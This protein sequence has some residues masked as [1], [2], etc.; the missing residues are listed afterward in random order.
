VKYVNTYND[1]NWLGNLYTFDGRVSTLVGDEKTHITIWECL[2]TWEKTDNCENCRYAPCN[3]RII[4]TEKN[5]K[6][7]LGFCS[8]EC[9]KNAR[10]DGFVKNTSW[11]KMDYLW[12]GRIW[13]ADPNKKEEILSHIQKHLDGKLS[14]ITWNKKASQKEREIIE[15]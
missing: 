6:K 3:A 2:Y 12:L 11:D 7:H 15:C 1:G 14:K 10:N 13:R 4:A 8:E 9:Y 5:Y